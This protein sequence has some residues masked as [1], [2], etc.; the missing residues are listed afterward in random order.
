MNVFGVN[1]AGDYS[2]V[3]GGPYCLT[4]RSL[5]CSDLYQTELHFMRWLNSD[6]QPYVYATVEVSN[7]GLN[8]VS[9]WD[10]AEG[11]ITDSSWTEQVFDIS[12][13][14]DGEPN[15][16]VR[17]GYEVGS[18]AWAYSGWNVDDI[19]IWGVPPTEPDCPA[20]L[21]GDGTVDVT[22][23]L[24][25]LGVWG[26]AGVPEDINGDGVVDILDF[27]ELIGSWGPC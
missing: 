12:G 13:V 11:T 27:L 18:G 7:N 25:L 21:N 16:Y 1:L 3:P 15:V 17:W 2:T 5:D 23:F 19:E 20:D 14:A 22:D 26:Q 4:L 6:Y 24:Q 8:W 9:L 10:N